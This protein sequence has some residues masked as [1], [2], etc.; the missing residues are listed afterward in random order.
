MALLVSDEALRATTRCPHD[1]D[2]LDSEGYPMCPAEKLI[3]G[4]GLFVKPKKRTGDPYLVPFG[5]GYICNC[6]VRKEFYTRYGV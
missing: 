5:T 3:P 2:C 1:F 6:P 4:N